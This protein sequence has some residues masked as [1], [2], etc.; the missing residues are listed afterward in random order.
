MSNDR[1][2]EFVLEGPIFE[3][4]GMPVEAAAELI[5]Y[6]ALVL[7]VAKKLYLRK[8]PH[9]ERSKR[10]LANEFDLRLTNVKQGSADVVIVLPTLPSPS[11]GSLL[12]FE[13]P[14]AIF[15]ESRDLISDT[16]G[17][18]AN[19]GQIS[20]AFPLKSLPKFR[21]LGKT[22]PDGHSIRLADP[23]GGHRSRMNSSVRDKFLQLL[24]AN[25]AELRQEAAGIIVEL[26]PER[27]IFHLRTS[28]GDRIQCF[29]GGSVSNIDRSL[30]ADENGEGPLVTVKGD[31]LV[32]SDGQLQ[33]F[34]LVDAVEVP[35]VAGLDALME[36]IDALDS[37]ED[38]WLGPRSVAVRPS[39][40]AYVNDAV[41]RLQLIPNGIATAPLPDGGV[42][43]EWSRGPVEYIAEVEA[44]G[45]LYLCILP[46][47]SHEDID[48]QLEAFSLDSFLRFVEDGEL[49]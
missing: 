8:N 16:I 20:P 30:L 6:K 22:L 10:Y 1:F 36:R 39:V 12:P 18:M 5:A 29:Y 49:D 43:F 44:D 4:E 38:G 34:T 11:Q 27:T 9:R 35:A 17:L 45:G 48:K 14:R 46:E 21:A 28:D 37:L 41:R 7:D 24:D 25:A 23:S 42:R 47:A 31:A 3:A 15:G 13:D 32:G 2:G 40:K 19:K 26:D 33:R